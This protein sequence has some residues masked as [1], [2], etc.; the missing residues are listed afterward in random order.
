[1]RLWPTPRVRSAASSTSASRAP[2][3]APRYGCPRYGGLAAECAHLRLDKRACSELSAAECCLRRTRKYVNRGAEN[4]AKKARVHIQPP[5]Q[6]FGALKGG[7]DGGLDIPHNKKRFAGF[8]KDDKK[9]DEETHA[10]YIMARP[11]VTASFAIAY[12]P[13]AVSSHKNA[14]TNEGSVASTQSFC[15][16]SRLTWRSVRGCSREA[17]L[18]RYSRA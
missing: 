1:M 9:L 5:S 18:L 4:W 12:C 16:T 13:S 8:D 3:P 11:R 14:L 2:P 17:R 10:Q 7:L 6:V 15:R